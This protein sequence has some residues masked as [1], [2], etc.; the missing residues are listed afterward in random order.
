MLG[1]R[2]APNGSTA[3]VL[4]RL[5]QTGACEITIPESVFDLDCPGHYLRRIKNV[6]LTIP[7]VVGPY[8]GVHCKLTLL[9]SETRAD[10]RLIPAA[11][12]CCGTC[13][14]RCYGPG[15]GCPG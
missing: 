1:R 9:S 7:C 14:D 5:R 10:P 2:T 12:Q 6:T 3:R 11:A 15:T 13:P 4:V 8:T